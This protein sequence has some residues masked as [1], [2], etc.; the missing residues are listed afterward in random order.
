[1]K[2]M[3]SVITIGILLAV[4]LTSVNAVPV[5]A[6][7]TAYRPQQNLPPFEEVFPGVYLYWQWW[8]ESS[9]D[10]P[11]PEEPP[12]SLEQDVY[13]YYVK[14]IYDNGY[15]IREQVEYTS[16]FRWSW[17]NLLVEIVVDPDGSL[18]SYLSTLDLNEGTWQLFWYVENST[19]LSGD[20][21]L[22]LSSFY[23]YT[24]M[25]SS[26][27]SVEYIWF[28]DSMNPVNASEVIP[29]LPE[30][31]AWAAGFNGSYHSS[32]TYDFKG[33]GFDVHEMVFSNNQT[34]WME[35]YFMGMTA[36]D[37]RNHNGIMDLIYNTVSYD[38]D[39]DGIVDWTYQVLNFSESEIVYEYYPVDA[40]IGDVATPHVNE[41]GEIEWSAEV[42]NING[43]FY[44]PVL[45][46]ETELAMMPETELQEINAS[47]PVGASLDSMSMTYRFGMTNDAA[48]LK[49]DQHIGQFTNS[50]TGQ[51]IPALEGLGLSLDYWSAFSTYDLT[52]QSEE[53]V[54]SAPP[55]A[56][57]ETSPTLEAQPLDSGNLSF[58]TDEGVLATV[59]FG[60][61]YVWGY[62]NN[63]YTVGTVF[64]PF[65]TYIGPLGAEQT[66]S[67]F[68]MGGT[69]IKDGIYYYSSC[70]SNWNGY[71]IT[72]DPIFAV[73]PE[74]PPGAVSSY[75]NILLTTSTVLAVGGSVALVAVVGRIYVIR[76]RE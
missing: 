16:E 43:T 1:M 52:V 3:L 21:A 46:D 70:Y 56:G 36:F 20:E 41:D 14:D 40:E 71:A 18:V 13:Y 11:L 22:L 69:D 23:Y 53:V 42:V 47:Q 6:E 27:F 60:G 30:D 68:E 31:Y 29:L 28:D 26:N 25:S 37:D 45:Y 63:T 32:Y 51:P 24:Y 8:N 15:W 58:N 64:Y 44:P 12:D 48:V 33:F 73:Y 76:R 17:N 10:I 49:I 67:G 34:H 72:H 38:F 75:V 9:Q 2:R 35:H 19:A 39:E 65:Y 5:T 59:D 57:I 74:V 62:D 61:T 7:T 4:L 66:A 54:V 50:T 55:D